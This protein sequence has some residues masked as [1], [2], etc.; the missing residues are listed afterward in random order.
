MRHH[1]ARCIR[2]AIRRLPT[3]RSPAIAVLCVALLLL[4]RPAGAQTP[5]APAAAPPP[6][7]AA[8]APA[9]TT[10][11]AAEPA[12]AQTPVAPGTSSAS[13]EL[14]QLREQTRAL[15]ARLAQLEQAQVEAQVLGATEGALDALPTQQKFQVYGFADFGLNHAWLGD[16]SF[17]RGLVSDETTFVLGNLNLYF[18]F[19]PDPAW[20]V[21]TEVRFTEYPHGVETALATP[22][23]GEYLRTDTEV[24]DV[25]SPATASQFRWGSIFIE[26]AYAQWSYDER[27][28]VRVGQFLTPYGIWNVDHGTPTLIALMMPHFVS[29]QTLPARQLGVDL[30]GAFLIGA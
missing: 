7:Q 30:H 21:L 23:G 29:A 4:A 11:P 8:T 14:E 27:F 6:A 22:L 9:I 28:N 16:K 2:G 3:T 25:A 1:F 18:D 20:Q 12:A 17:V 5:A 24:V 13:S 15:E 10:P 26:R 19:R